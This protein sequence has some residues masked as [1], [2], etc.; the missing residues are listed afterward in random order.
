PAQAS[1]RIPALAY[2]HLWSRRF[3]EADDFGGEICGP[4]IVVAGVVL[5]QERFWIRGDGVECFAGGKGDDAVQPTVNEQF[6]LPN[7]ANAQVRPEGV[8]DQKGHRQEGVVRLRQR[9]Y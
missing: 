5:N 7:A 2:R 3:D 6:R 8:T 4:D 9:L 1:F